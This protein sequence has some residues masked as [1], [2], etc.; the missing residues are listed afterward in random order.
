MSYREIADHYGDG[1]SYRLR[2]PR[3]RFAEL[4]FGPLGRETLF[5][6]RAAPPLVGLGL[7]DAV[8][9][10][11]I[12]AIAAEEA[13][14]GRVR[15]RP[16]KVFDVAAGGLRLGRFGWKAGLP[17]LKQQIANAFNRDIGITNPLYPENDC[18]AVERACRA[19]AAAAQHHPK[20]GEDVLGAV[21]FFVAHLAPPAP[22][23][24]DDPQAARG[25]ALFDQAG[26]AA[27]HRPTLE[28]GDDPDAALAHQTI[29]PY[30]DLL[31]H[32]LGAGLADKRPEYAADGRMW[33]TAPLWGLGLTL[34]VNGHEF[35]LHDGRARGPAEA[36]LWHGG[37]A[38][39]AREAFRQ[40]EQ[41]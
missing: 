5:S 16:N 22:R 9:D 34:S 27:C 28:T 40:H 17:S 1:E 10:E 26:C 7:L 41:G 29:H 32:D 3:Y 30:T 38:A 23:R 37:E 6:V 24:P 12:L 21:T 2:A 14:A 19:A 33:R 25:A 4:A 8:S 36:I 11:T 31:L 13:K 35:L 20:I 18:T 15:G 39:A